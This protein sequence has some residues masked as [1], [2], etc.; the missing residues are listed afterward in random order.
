MAYTP[1]QSDQTGGHLQKR[2]GIGTYAVNNVNSYEGSIVSVPCELLNIGGWNE[3]TALRWVMLFDSLTA[4]SNGSTPVVNP[5]RVGQGKNFS[6][7]LE[8]SFVFNNGVYWIVSST[9]PTLTVDTSATFNVMAAYL[10]VQ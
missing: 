1:F 9:Q 7:T 5:I 6:W 10:S 8:P 2:L 4:P 3:G